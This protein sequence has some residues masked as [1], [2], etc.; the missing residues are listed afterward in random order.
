MG[1][2]PGSLLQNV[3]FDIGGP[4]GDLLGKSLGI[5]RVEGSEGFFVA[6]E[7][8][9]EGGHDADGG[10]DFDSCTGIVLA[11]LVD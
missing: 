10:V 2:L 9:G 7:I 11:G 4:I 3:D 8:A 5:C 1:K 6:W